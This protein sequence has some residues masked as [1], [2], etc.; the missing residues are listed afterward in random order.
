MNINMAQDAH[1]ATEEKWRQK[2]TDLGIRNV[3]LSDWA[4]ETSQALP[5]MFEVKGAFCVGLLLVYS[6]FITVPFRT[7]YLFFSA[8]K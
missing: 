7:V 6:F 5:E 3:T 2:E 1:T 8:I 4:F